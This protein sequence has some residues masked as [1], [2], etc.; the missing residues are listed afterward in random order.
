MT[1]AEFT[2]KMTNFVNEYRN[3]F[4]RYLSSAFLKFVSSNKFSA[5]QM[6]ALCEIIARNVVHA[7]VPYE[8]TRHG[9]SSKDIDIL[10]TSTEP[11]ILAGVFYK[12]ENLTPEQMEF[13]IL[14][15]SQEVRTKA[16][17][18][19]CCTEAQK[20][21]MCLMYGENSVSEYHIQGWLR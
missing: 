19:P 4:T 10:L 3:E 7:R 21:K 16:F 6:T 18:N 2:Q 9:I 13:G 11:Y 20:V 5:T 15:S 14:H 8:M 17:Y 12:C 1:D